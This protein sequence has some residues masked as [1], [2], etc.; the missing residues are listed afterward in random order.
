MAYKYWQER[1]DEDELEEWTDSLA[2]LVLLGF[3]KNIQAQNY[4]F[5]T[6]KEIYSNKDNV[7][8]SFRTTQMVL[9]EKEWNIKALKNRKRKL[10]EKINEV[11]DIF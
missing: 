6:K 8:T 11:I 10:I 7:A 2:N 4:D 1:F 9:R 5:P 3:R